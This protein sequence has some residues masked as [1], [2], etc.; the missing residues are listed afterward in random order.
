MTNDHGDELDSILD[1]ALSEYSN[2][3]P[4]AGLESR[5]L[6]RVQ[7][8]PPE[9]QWW[10]IAGLALIAAVAALI[11]F[12][13]LPAR[14]VPA[15]LAL[16]PPAVPPVAEVVFPKKTPASRP[17][18][19]RAQEAH[20]FP[21]PVPLTPEERAL[22]RFVEQQPEGAREALVQSAQIDPITIAPLEIEGLQ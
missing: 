14:D 16:T 6:R 18:V 2:A 7:S 12:V 8:A 17:A 15:A 5:I 3:E 19:H 20:E 13:R 9:R 4:R 22:L 10:P 1:A 21:M 11:V